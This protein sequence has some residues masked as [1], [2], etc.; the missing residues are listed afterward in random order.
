MFDLIRFFEKKEYVE[1]FLNGNLFMNSIGHFRKSG[2]A[3]QNDIAEGIGET[4]APEEF[5]L[6]YNSNLSTCFDKKH[7]I[8]PFMTSIEAMKYCHV[9]CLSLHAHYLLSE[10]QNPFPVHWCCTALAVLLRDPP[11]SVP[12][13]LSASRRRRP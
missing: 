10:F 13:S 8:F 4:L 9:C 1:D 12:R 5:D 6:K 3:I 7:F 2:I 11:A